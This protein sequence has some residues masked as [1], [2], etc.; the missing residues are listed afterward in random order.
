M[1]LKKI[2]AI[3]AGDEIRY[4][5]RTA[6]K[7]QVLANLVVEFAKPLPEEGRGA[8]STDGKLVGTVSQQEPIC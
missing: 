4:M 2:G 1:K 5:P 8:L 3:K 7:G 6:V